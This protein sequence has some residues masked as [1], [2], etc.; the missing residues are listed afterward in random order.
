MTSAQELLDAGVNPKNIPT[1]TAELNRK[2]FGGLADTEFMVEAG[3]FGNTDPTLQLGLNWWWDTQGDRTQIF[4]T[5]QPIDPHWMTQGKVYSAGR[6]PAG[7]KNTGDM[8]AQSAGYAN[9]RHWFDSMAKA[10]KLRPEVVEEGFNEW[11]KEMLEVGKD[12]ALVMF[13]QSKRPLEPETWTHEFNHIGQLL[14]RKAGIKA[15]IDPQEWKDSGVT[16]STDEEKQRVRDI[17]MSSPGDTAYEDAHDWLKY[18]RKD[19]QGKPISYTPDEIKKIAEHVLIEDKYANQVLESQGGLAKPSG[20][21]SQYEKQH[22][23]G[24]WDSMMNKIKG[25]FD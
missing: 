24:F 2:E 17:M 16:E 11:E 22:M 15:G 7:V 1:L 14:L 12:P 21:L 8:W 19:D 20:D 9:G 13:I 3:R 18:T 5:G 25:L 4:D 10:G 6:L 23:P